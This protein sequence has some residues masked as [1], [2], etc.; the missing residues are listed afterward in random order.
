M[1]MWLRVVL[2]VLA[3]WRVT[4]LLASED[5]P[6]DLIVRFRSVLG[7]GFAGKLLD[8][9][10]CLSLWIAAPMALFVSRNPV[11]WIFSWLALSGGACLLESVTRETA[12][13][14]PMAATAQGDENHVLRTETVVIAEHDGAEHNAADA[15]ADGGRETGATGAGGAGG[16]AVAGSG[17]SPRS[18]FAA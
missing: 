11:E 16:E 7:D 14:E 4:H 1:S 9:F 3:T 15:A 17:G 2:G 8:C 6:A 18:G 5:G 10:Y 13:I 12:V